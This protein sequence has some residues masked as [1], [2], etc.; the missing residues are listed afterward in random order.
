MNQFY[1]NKDKE[2]KKKKFTI[3]INGSQDG[4]TSTEM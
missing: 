1:Q 2:S 3:D 4:S